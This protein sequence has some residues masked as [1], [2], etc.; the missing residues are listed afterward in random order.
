MDDQKWNMVVDIPI[1]CKTSHVV[2]S[3]N[4]I[5]SSEMCAPPPVG[6]CEASIAIEAFPFE[7][8]GS[9][10][11]LN[12]VGENACTWY[13]PPGLWYELSGDGNCYS[14][15]F[16]APLVDGEFS[17]KSISIMSGTSCSNLACVENDSIFSDV[18]QYTLNTEAGAS[19]RIHLGTEL[20]GMGTEMS[21]EIKVSYN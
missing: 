18:A 21:G 5:Q 15:S 3:C 6:T 2:A 14:I 4:H 13:R 9:T 7:I 20:N 17:Q 8:S 19:Y 11:N 1:V 12:A 16:A 10:L